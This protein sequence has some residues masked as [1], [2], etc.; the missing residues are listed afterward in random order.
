MNRVCTACAYGLAFLVLGSVS[1]SAQVTIEVMPSLSVPLTASSESYAPGF[2]TDLDGYLRFADSPLLLG[3]GLGIA[4]IPTRADASVTLIDGGIA[5]G[6]VLGEGRGLRLRFGLRA[7]GYLS[8]YGGAIGA[9][10][11]AAGA[12]TL[13]IPVAPGLDVGLRAGYGYYSDFAP[14]GG[15]RHPLY[16]GLSASVAIGLTPSIAVDPSSRPPRIEIAPPRFD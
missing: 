6:V 15:L 3:G 7:G 12:I 14:E 13:G 5:T 16:H 1:P 8:V 10:P 11:H 4:L 2:A 9:N